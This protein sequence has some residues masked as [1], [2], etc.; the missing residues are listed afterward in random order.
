MTEAR[1]NDPTK[2]AGAAAKKRRPETLADFMELDS[3]IGILNSSEFVP[4]GANMSV[5][6]GKKFAALLYEKYQK[7][8]EQARLRYERERAKCQNE[9]EPE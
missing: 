5:D 2:N 9:Q 4:G 3:V 7:E 1:K 8:Q 6:T